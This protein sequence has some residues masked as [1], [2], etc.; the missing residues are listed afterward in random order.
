[1]LSHP[2]VAQ[3]V[4]LYSSIILKEDV[5]QNSTRTKNSWSWQSMSKDRNSIDWEMQKHMKTQLLM[6]IITFWY[7]FSTG[8]IYCISHSRIDIFSNTRKR[9]YFETCLIWE[10]SFDIMW[11]IKTTEQGWSCVLPRDFTPEIKVLPAQTLWTACANTDTPTQT[12][13]IK[14]PKMHT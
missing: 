13:I 10:R 5:T 6:Q 4:Q 14:H 3:A 1:M 9:F 11:I 2:F 7:I 8:T 12:E